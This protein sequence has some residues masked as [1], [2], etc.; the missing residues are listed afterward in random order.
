MVL[1]EQRRT[2]NSRRSVR[3]HMLFPNQPRCLGVNGVNVSPQVP[4]QSRPA[5]GFDYY[6]GPDCGLRFEAPIYATASRV[7]R[8]DRAILTADKHTTGEYRRL[9][10]DRGA[11]WETESPPDLQLWYNRG[12]EPGDRSRLKPGARATHAPAIPSGI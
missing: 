3:I 12:I 10:I 6:C 9:G 11:T 5:A 1:N 4:K 7:E 2:C 8:I